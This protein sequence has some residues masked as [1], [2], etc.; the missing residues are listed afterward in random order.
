MAGTLLLINKKIKDKADFEA[1]KNQL[2]NNIQRVFSDFYPGIHFREPDAKS[3]L[4]EFRK[5]NAIKFFI[6]KSGNWLSY[7]G[8]VFALDE[9]KTY[10]AEELLLL[11]FSDKANFA[12]KLD[13]HFVIKLYDAQ[14]DKHIVI[15]DFIKNKTNFLCETDDY[16]MFTP[17]VI[18]SASI[19]KPDPDPEAINEFL[20]RYYIL[21]E[22]SILKEVN[23]LLPA[24]EYQVVN[25]IL[26]R[27]TY[28]NWPQNYTKLKFK[29]AV[30]RMAN[31]MKES[32]VLISNSFGQPCIDFTMGQDTRQ[33]I[34]A[35]T[36]Q[37][38]KFTTS[39]FGKSDFY[40]V[41]KVG[42]TARTKGII[43]HNIQLK[44]DY[45]EQLW[46]HF[47]KAVV[48]GSCE[49]PGY[50]LGRIMYMR[51]QQAKYG[52]VSL[53][54]VDGHFYKNGLWDEMYTFNLYREP[55]AFNTN[56][57]LKLRAL[58]KKYNDQIF[59]DQF[60]AV[61]NNSKSYFRNIIDNSIKDYLNSPVSIQVD[62]FDMYH[63][64]NF[65]NVANT[66]GN[67]VHNTISPLLLRRNLEFA[68]QIPVR[69]KFN[70]SK[71]QRA[72]VY[73]L[74]PEL[75]KVKTDFGGVNMVPKNWITSIP[76]YFRYFYFQSERLRKKILSKIGFK[77]TSHLQEAWNYLPLY[78]KLY[79]D[80]EFRK[81][82]AFETLQLKSI[83][84]EKEWRE[85]LS[86]YDSEQKNMND[87]EYLF[88]IA[89]AEHFLKQANNWN[90][91]K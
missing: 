91:K 79:N 73:K 26:S 6:D 70:L 69:W 56:A 52:R 1:T 20:W 39:V 27:I 18:T 51:E 74:D 30:E 89:S 28:W 50:Q 19:K 59:T 57:F 84:K 7:E 62:R 71:F 31:T 85:L 45:T 21:S 61:K 29:G 38:A 86:S 16:C 54:G 47:R 11:Y 87:F 23:R 13:G 2:K 9:T 88:K 65:A 32:A 41:K 4:V 10:N 22:K 25:G 53:N 33:V 77:V 76:F 42:D 35:F 82:L 8:T 37:N 58:S 46:L 64:L 15:N 36:N 14:K 66:G 3:F 5:D 68:L 43:N 78:K 12:N 75:A 17:F 49:E 63:W 90:S 55:K 48:L 34:S 81:N 44:D 83:I 67:L 80:S 40:E 60:L 24:S 72:L